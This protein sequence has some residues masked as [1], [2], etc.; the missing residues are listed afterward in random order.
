M[1]RLPD[2]DHSKAA[3]LNSLRSPASRRA[4]EFALNEFIAW[5]CSEPRL[6]FNRVVVLRYRLSM[7]ARGLAAASINQR[8][9]AVRRLAYEASDC[10]LL[11]PDLAAG[12]RRV[13]GVRQLGS[14][15]GNWL[16]LEQ[17]SELLRGVKGDDARGKRNRAILSTLVGCG[18]RRTELAELRIENIQMRQGKWAIVDLVGKGGHIRTVPVPQWVKEALDGW[19]S[20]AGITRGRVF[21]AVS[22]GGYAWGMGVT[23][24]VVWTVV[25][26]VCKRS[27]IDNVAPH[28]LRRTCAKLCHGA[29]G[30][31]EQIQ[32]LLGH[33]SIQTTERYIGCQQNLGSPVN[34]RFRLL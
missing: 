27:G 30:E 22:R 16:R 8:L 5:Y 33:I 32:F 3:I 17:C 2:L 13:K 23:P 21:R 11:S 25:R 19:I 6:A 34:E 29:G 7:E 12:I 4:Y 28:D 1:L 14:R 18:L 26:D 24:N 15:S 31:L 9:A 10:G 20:A